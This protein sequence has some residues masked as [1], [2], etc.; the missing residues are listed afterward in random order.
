MKS[1]NIGI[2][3]AQRERKQP[4]EYTFCGRAYI[5]Y[6][7][8][9]ED[10]GIRPIVSIIPVLDPMYA[11]QVVDKQDAIVLIGGVSVHPMIYNKRNV[12]CTDLIDLDRDLWE[13]EVFRQ[14]Y[15]KKL[16]V[17]GICR[18]HQLIM[19]ASGLTLNESLASTKEAYITH[20]IE[21]N[22]RGMPIHTISDTFDRN[23]ILQEI[24][25]SNNIYVNSIHDQGYILPSKKRI[26]TDLEFKDF[27][28]K[29]FQIGGITDDGV[30][31]LIVN[32]EHKVLT[33]QYHPEEMRDVEL[34]KYFSDMIKEKM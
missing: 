7:L 30:V 26:Q 27:T 16:P 13:V 10:F 3:A 11:K 22:L 2:C 28:E 4:S 23:G 17:L 21:N 18:G 20:H 1:L 8:M 6:I 31:E 19:A 25:N 24:Y 32:K 5:D 15:A 14:A 12:E 34:L 29:G 9:L 33:V